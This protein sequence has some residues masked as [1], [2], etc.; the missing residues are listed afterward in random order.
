MILYETSA[1]SIERQKA[2][3]SYVEDNSTILLSVE[4]TSHIVTCLDHLLDW[5]ETGRPLGD[6]LTNL[7]RNDLKSTLATADSTNKKGIEIYVFFCHW[8]LPYNYKKKIKGES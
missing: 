3:E 5:Y 6:F 2:L 1:G 8:Q 4:E 7:L